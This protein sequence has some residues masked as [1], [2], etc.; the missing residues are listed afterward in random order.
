MGI[1]WV[2]EMQHLTGS[3]TREELEKKY[4]IDL[5]PRAIIYRTFRD[6]IILIL[7]GIIYYLVVRFTGF[8]LKCYFH[9]I[10]GLDCPAC[11]TTRM[12]VSTS[13]LDFGRAFRYN[14]FMF[15]SF[16]FVI[17]EVMYFLY[18]NEAKK[19]VNKVNKVIIYIW[20]GLFVLYGVI[21]NIFPI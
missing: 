1:I 20:L 13:R 2:K 3:E 9:E 4:G 21:R 17:A 6:I 19:P 16:P 11:G 5:S 7:V 10:T 15:I 18:I 14:R 8:G 12:I